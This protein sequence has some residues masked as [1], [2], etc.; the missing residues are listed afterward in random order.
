MKIFIT[1]IKQIREN[2]CTYSLRC[3]VYTYTK[4]LLHANEIILKNTC[5]YMG[6]MD[7]ENFHSRNKTN[8]GKSVYI[9]PVMYCIY[10]ANKC[11]N[12]IWLILKNRSLHVI[13]FRLISKYKTSRHEKPEKSV[14]LLS[15]VC[16]IQGIIKI[17][18]QGYCVWHVF[19]DTL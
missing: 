14:L 6:I 17:N 9:F 8:Q 3:I 18:T 2:L 13:V 15:L 7:N 12:E 10:I 16:N 1:S 11:I 5:E 19:F 4:G